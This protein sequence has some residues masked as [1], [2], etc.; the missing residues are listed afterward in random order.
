M[1]PEMLVHLITTKAFQRGLHKSLWRPNCIVTMNP[2]NHKGPKA[3]GIL[4]G[5]DAHKYKHNYFGCKAV[6]HAIFN[7]LNDDMAAKAKSNSLHKLHKQ[8]ENSTLSTSTTAR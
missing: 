8:V 3:C 7:H 2:V 1:A 5:V 6:S 4:I